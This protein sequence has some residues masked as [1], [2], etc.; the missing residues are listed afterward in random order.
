MAVTTRVFVGVSGSQ[1]G[2]A[3][4]RQAW[5][6]AVRR[7]AVLVP[8][9][10]W[11][12]VGGEPAYRTHPC[13]PLAELWEQAARE[14]LEAALTEAFGDSPAAVRIEPLVVRGEAGP[15]LTAIADRPGDL[16]VVGTGRRGRLARLLHGS[17]SR[18]C[19]AHAT[20]SVVAVPP[21][22][23]PAAPAVVLSHQEWRTL[24]AA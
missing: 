13:P 22:D 4:L 3:V 7:D 21:T 20:C 8:V 23:A 14:R 2:S 16:L 10:A 24:T 5:G 18:H 19:L 12:P 17:V 11:T 6:E 9:L 15:V 1:R